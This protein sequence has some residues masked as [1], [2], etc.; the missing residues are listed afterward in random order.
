MST[1]AKLLKARADNDRPEVPDSTGTWTWRE[2]IDAGAFAAWTC[3]QPDLGVKWIPRFVR[4]TPSL[5]RT[6]TKKVTK[7]ELRGQA[8]RCDEPLWWRP[9]PRQP[10]YRPLQDHE[11]R[12]LDEQLAM[13]SQPARTGDA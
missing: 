8:W 2:T 5:P 6:A 12:Q 9:D 7:V 11:K 1:I 4:I 13:R 10:A 3:S